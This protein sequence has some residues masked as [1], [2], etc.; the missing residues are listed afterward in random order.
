M[1]SVR[2]LARVLGSGRIGAAVAHQIAMRGI[3]NI[4]LVEIIE[5]LPRCEAIDITQK[6]SGI[7]VDVSGSND[8]HDLTNSERP[9]FAKSAET[10]PVAISGL[11]PRILA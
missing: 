11:A 1:A 6:I 3:C 5:G 8:F 7:D 2:K 10:L 4:R 9:L